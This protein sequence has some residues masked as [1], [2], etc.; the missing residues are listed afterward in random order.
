MSIHQLNVCGSTQMLRALR[1][2]LEKAEAHAKT[3]GY[4]PGNLLLARLAPDMHSLAKQ[5]QFVCTQAREV[6]SRLGGKP[7]P[8][9]QPPSD[10]DEARALIDQTLE[11][12]TTSEAEEIDAGAS[13]HVVIELTGGL[14]FEMK[15]DEYATNWATPQF[16]F[17]LITAYCILRHNGIP[18]GKADYVPHMFA[19]IRKD[20]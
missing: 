9:L 16:Y 8:T 7:L 1:G 2:Q 12:L 20:G 5:I 11:Y 6:I 4:D 17:H 14:A 18:L 19:W 15:G 10:M 13:R 3:L